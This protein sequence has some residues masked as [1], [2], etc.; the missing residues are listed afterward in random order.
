LYKNIR[1]LGEATVA[2]VLYVEDNFDNYKLVEF[3]L[4]KNG[5]NVMNAVDGLD[6]LEK[7]KIY[8][9][10]LIIMDINLPNLKGLEAATIINQTLKRNISLLLY[11][12]LL[13]IWNTG[14]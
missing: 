3:I 14:K 5:F 9:P 13:R 8:K 10:D 2:N 12:P 1:I 6:A 11:L 7:A 4:S